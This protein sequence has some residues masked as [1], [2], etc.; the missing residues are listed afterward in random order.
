MADGAN[1]YGG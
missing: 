1:E